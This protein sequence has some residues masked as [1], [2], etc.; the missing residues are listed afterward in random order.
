MNIRTKGRDNIAFYVLVSIG[1]AFF[2]D[3]ILGIDATVFVKKYFGLFRAM[4][5]SGVEV[6]TKSMMFLMYM[7]FSPLLIV[8][9]RNRKL[10]MPRSNVKIIF[11]L[12]LGG[13]LLGSVIFLVAFL[14]EFAPYQI[15]HSRRG[16]LALYMKAMSSDVLFGLI[17]PTLMG[18]C[19]LAF[20]GAYAG[21]LE[22]ITRFKIIYMKS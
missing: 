1:L 21:A 20:Y 17:C 11:M 6:R 2:L 12:V 16:Q 3:S 22:L 5:A 14:F 4:E 15:E 7:L 13:P 19:I 10:N 18:I 9:L 8:H